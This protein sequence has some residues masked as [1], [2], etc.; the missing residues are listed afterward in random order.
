M[1]EPDSVE[2]LKQE[3]VI[4]KMETDIKL[5]R[6]KMLAAAQNLEFEQAAIIRDQ[7]EQLEA[8]EMALA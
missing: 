5:L 6:K 2:D 4:A 3:E 8:K 1:I 7:I